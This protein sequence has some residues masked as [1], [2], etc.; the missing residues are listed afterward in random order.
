MPVA[1]FLPDRFTDYRMWSDIPERISDRVRS[2]HY[3]RYSL[4]PWSAPSG[5]LVDT[6]RAMAHGGTFDVVAAAGQAARFGFAL[7]EAGL[8]RGVAFFHPSL[9][10]I[11]DDVEVDF[12]DLDET[13]ELYLPIAAAVQ[14]PDPAR[15]NEIL[16]SA[17]RALAGQE[18]PAAEAELAVAMFADH[19]DEL[20]AELRS[21]EQA[22]TGPP[23]P[24]PPWVQRPWIDRLGELTV[25]VTA[26][27]S[28][29]GL[30]VGEAIARRAADTHIVVA[31]ASP[32][33][34]P[35]AERDRSAQA[36]LQLL[37]RS[38]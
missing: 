19:A 15:R 26:V 17:V 36:L 24:D 5:E 32:G 13:L 35:P 25:P 18:M 7:A 30:S 10:R 4:L 11:P 2:V 31:D 22:A 8:A 28:Q 23:Q 21:A 14:E 37:D 33:L 34:A 9:D 6:A 16:V 27:V 12:S 3:D 20:F 38:S 1:L 29:R